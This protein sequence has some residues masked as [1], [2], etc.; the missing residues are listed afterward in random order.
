MSIELQ[1]TK[2]DLTKVSARDLRLIQNEVLS[3]IAAR[4]VAGDAAAAHDSHSSSHSKNSVVDMERM[5]AG[6]PGNVTRT[7]GG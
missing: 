2:I 6:F 3:A 4:L 1:S 7:V 5:A